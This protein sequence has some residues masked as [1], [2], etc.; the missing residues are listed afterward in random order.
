MSRFHALSGHGIAGS[1]L[2]ELCRK[3]CEFGRAQRGVAAIE[4][5]LIAPVMIL[6]LLGISE[7][8]VSVNTDRKLVSVTRTVADLTGRATTT[9]TSDM[10]AVFAAASVV[11][12]P[13][14]LTNAKIVVSSIVVS[15]SGTTTTGTVAWSCVNGSGPGKRTPGSTYPV[16]VSFTSSPSF[17]LVESTM[18]YT[19]VLGGQ[20]TSGIINF[21]ET[22][23]WPVRNGSQVAWSG[24]AC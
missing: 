7:V 18:A 11:M 17:I 3:A 10:A 8:T 4:F 19:P 2:L 9:S 24:T 5:A 14:S 23:P 21:N 20:F 16:P 1:V 22:L 15:T 12:Q 6:V 13:Y